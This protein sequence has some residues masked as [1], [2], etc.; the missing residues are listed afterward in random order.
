MA[1]QLARLAAPENWNYRNAPAQFA[2]PILHSYLHYT[3]RR[4]AAEKDKIAFAE[5]SDTRQKIAAF[6]T[7][8]VTEYFEPI[9]SAFHENREKDTDVDWVLIGF[10]KESQ[11]PMTYFAVHPERADYFDNPTDLLYD[12]SV[13]LVKDL[14]HIVDD[15]ENAQRT[16]IH[17]GRIGHSRQAADR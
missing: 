12:R 2:Y 6:N 8:L 1:S 5:N 14:K 9:Y 4:I 15:R 10:F 3:F 13:K 7:G 11:S 17:C 16:P